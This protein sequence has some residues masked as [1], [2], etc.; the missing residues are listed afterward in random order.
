MA[1]LFILSSQI[2]LEN[3]QEP[4]F[5]AS[6]NQTL[7]VN[8]TDPISTEIPLFIGNQSNENQTNYNS[9]A[10]PALIPTLE[11]LV[12]NESQSATP[13]PN[14]AIPSPAEPEIIPDPSPA[15]PSPEVQAP[16]ADPLCGQTISTSV[17]LTGDLKN[18]SG[19]TICPG[20]G[21]T[22]ISHNLVLDCNGY[23]I[24]G[25]RSSGSDGVTSNSA[26][27]NTIKNCIINNFTIGV[28]FLNNIR[29]TIVNST[30]AN[31]SNFG[32]YIF[33]SSGSQGH[34]I[35]IIDTVI[36]STGGTGIGITRHYN[37]TL[38]RLQ[39][40]GTNVGIS[41]SLSNR[42]LI[43]K[44]GIYKI[45]TNS[46]SISNSSFNSILNLDMATGSQGILL[47]LNS[48]NNTIFNNSIKNFSTAAIKLD[49]GPLTLNEITKNRIKDSQYGI[50]I[51]SATGNRIYDN[52]F[53]MNTIDAY[54]N[55]TNQWNI[56]KK[57]GL[58]VIGGQFIS[59]NYWDGYTGA[60]TNGDFIGDTSLPYKSENTIL[61]GGDYGPLVFPTPFTCNGNISTSLPLD[62]DI[63]N[64]N[65]TGLNIIADN[66]ILDCNG[67]KISGNGTGMGITIQGRVNVTIANCM[68]SKFDTGI[69]ASLA[70]GNIKNNT[71]SNCSYGI[72]GGNFHYSKIQANYLQ[73]NTLVGISLSNAQNS[74]IVGNIVNSMNKTTSSYGIKLGLLNTY[75]YN[76]T[77]ENNTAINSNIG[78]G[79]T[80]TPGIIPSGGNARNTIRSN[81][82]SNNYKGIIFSS[83]Y[84]NNLNNSVYDNYFNN[85]IN[86][87]DAN[88]FNSWNTTLQAGPNIMGG[89]NISGNF[90]S[91][92][93]G[94]DFDFDGLGDTDIPYTSG[95]NIT[96]GG[97][98][99]PLAYM[100]PF[101]VIYDVDAYVGDASPD[102]KCRILG[103]AF[104]GPSSFDVQLENFTGRCPGNIISI[105]NYSIRLGIAGAT[106]FGNRGSEIFITDKNAPI[107]A[108][109]SFE[110]SLILHAGRK[111][112]EPINHPFTY[113]ITAT[114]TWSPPQSFGYTIYA[115]GIEKYYDTEEFSLKK[116]FKQEG[117]LSKKC[118]WDW[119]L[120]D[121]ATSPYT[122]I[123]DYTKVYARG[124]SDH[125][126]W[127]PSKINPF[128]QRIRLCSRGVWRD[129]KLSIK[130]MLLEEGILDL[131]WINTQVGVYPGSIAY[132][133]ELQF[134]AKYVN[135][136]GTTD[137]VPEPG[138]VQRQSFDKESTN[139]NVKLQMEDGTESLYAITY[140]TEPWIN[141]TNGTAFL[142]S[143]EGVK[144]FTR[145]KTDAP[146]N[147]TR[148]F[149]QL[150]ADCGN[151]SQ[152]A[153]YSDRN[154]DGIVEAGQYIV[155]MDGFEL[156]G[157]PVS[158]TMYGAFNYTPPTAII[159]RIRPASGTTG[160]AQEGEDVNFTGHGIPLN[161]TIDHWWK[162][163][164]S[165][166][167]GSIASFNTKLLPPANPHVI[168]YYVKDKTGLWSPE[169]DFS[170]QTLIVNKP[171]VA[172]VNFIKGIVDDSGTLKAVAGESIDFS[173]YGFDTDGYVTEETWII[174][175]QV[176]P[177]STQYAYPE[178]TYGDQKVIFYARDNTGTYSKNVTKT[179]HVIKRP[180]ILAH[181]YLRSPSEMDDLKKALQADNYQVYTVDLRKPVSADVNF[182]IPL[183]SDELRTLAIVYA[184][185]EKTRTFYKDIKELMALNG[186]T[187]ESIF[188]AKNK[189]KASL[190]D[191]KSALLS[192]RYLVSNES[193]VYPPMTS[194]IDTLSDIESHLNDA[195]SAIYLYNLISDDKFF[196]NLWKNVIRNYEIK[197]DYTLKKEIGILNLSLPVPLPEKV[198]PAV[199]GLVET[200]VIKIP[201]SITLFS[202]EFSATKGNYT[203][204]LS[205]KL[206]VKYIE[207]KN[208]EGKIKLKG[209]LVISDI[210]FGFRGKIPFVGANKN[211]V[212]QQQEDAGTGLAPDEIS[213]LD[214]GFD[215][216]V[217]QGNANGVLRLNTNSMLATPNN[218]G[219]GGTFG[220]DV[221][222]W[223][224]GENG[225]RYI[226][227]TKVANNA[228]P[229]IS[230]AYIGATEGATVLDNDF[231]IN[232][233]NATNAGLRTGAYHF[234][235]PNL[236][237]GTIVQDAEEEAQYF[238]D[239]ARAFINNNHLP[240]MLDIE[241]R[242][243]S[244][245]STQQLS[246]WISTWSSYIEDRT[247]I[248]PIL[249]MGRC[250][251]CS[252]SNSWTQMVEPRITTHIL[253]V[254]R[255]QVRTI[256]DDYENIGA[257]AV[258][259]SRWRIW[260]FSET[261]RISG[262][263]GDV[264]LNYYR[265]F[266]E[267]L[268]EQSY[269]QQIVQTSGTK[270]ADQTEENLNIDLTDSDQKY[271]YVSFSLK[272]SSSI[273]DLKLANADIRESAKAIGQKIDK[274]KEKTGVSA[275]NLVGSGMG[276]MAANYYT[277]YG[278]RQDVKKVI[279]IGSP[280][281]GSDLIKFGPKFIKGAIDALSNYIPVGG[282]ILAEIIKFA[283]DLILGEAAVQMEPES[284]FV[285][286]MNLN[287][288]N[289]S[290]E[291]L[292][293]EWPGG[294]DFTNKNVQYLNLF[295]VGPKIGIPL[296]LTLT[297]LRLT[298][299]VI[300]HTFE[301]L[302]IWWGDLFTNTISAKQ[303]KMQ[304]KEI[305]GWS[306]FHWWIAG[307]G[308]TINAVKNFLNG[309]PVAY[310]AST[311]STSQAATTLDNS[312]MNST[313]YEVLGPYYGFL[314]NTN[315]SIMDHLP[316][317][318]RSNFFLDIAAKDKVFKLTYKPTD[319]VWVPE[320]DDYA[321]CNNSLNL[322]IIRPDGSR[323]TP[324]MANNGSIIYIDSGNEIYYLINE[325]A[326]GNW[327]MEVGGQ[328]IT[329]EYAEYTTE[330]TY[331]S[332]L[333]MLVTTGNVST[334]EP[335]SGVKIMAMLLYNGSIV[336]GANMTAEITLYGNFTL[337]ST[338]PNMTVK[339]FD[340][341][342]HGDRNSNDGY[343]AFNFTNTSAE[344]AYIVK[345]IAVVNSSKFGVGGAIV[346]RSAATAFIIEKPIDLTLNSTGI[347]FSNP[348]PLH[349]NTVRLD[350]II[351]NKRNGKAENAEIE[352]RDNLTTL[353]FAII[354]VTG[355]NQTVASVLW[356]AT[357]GTHNIT[358]IVSPFNSFDETNYS[359]NL[360]WKVLNVGD[361]VLPVADAGPD[362]VA[363][364][365][366]PVFFDASP[367]YDNNKIVTYQ[368]DTHLG[369]A[370]SQKIGGV[371]NSIRGYGLL[372][373]H[374]VQLT[375]TDAAGNTDT[376]TLTVY[377]TNDYDV[378]NPVAFAGYD[379][380][381]YIGDPIQFN[382]TAGHDNYGIASHIWDIDTS[383]DSDGD[384]IPDN[385]ADLVTRFPRLEKG[386][387]IPGTY[388]VK[389]T[390][391]DV[392]SNGPREDEMT[393]AV[394]DRISYICLQ[395]K[396]C[397]QIIDEED[398]C[399]NV[400]NTDQKDYDNDGIGDACH[401]NFIAYSQQELEDEMANAWNGETI[402][403]YTPIT[404]SLYIQNSNFTLDCLGALVITND[405]M[406]GIVLQSTA[407]NVTVQNCIVSGASNGIEAFGNN[408]RLYK[409]VI[410]N[411][412]NSGIFITGSGGELRGNEVCSNAIKDIN[413]TGAYSGT[414][415]TC[416]LTSNWNDQSKSG[417]TFRCDPCSIPSNGLILPASMRLCPGSFS[418]P[419]G[420]QAS[421]NNIT[422][423]C[424]D[425][426]LIGGMVPGIAGITV[427]G[428]DYV[429]IVGCDISNYSIGI[430]MKDST[431]SQA[432]YNLIHENSDGIIYANSPRSTIF[433]NTIFANA[434]TQVNLS[435]AQ[436]YQLIG[437]EIDAGDGNGNISAI[438]SSS[439]DAIVQSNIIKGGVKVVGS[440][441]AKVAGNM[442]S[443]PLVNSALHLASGA[444]SAEVT[445]NDISDAIFIGIHAR[446][447][448]N[449]FKNNRIHDVPYGI[450]LDS[451]SGNSLLNDFVTYVTIG[452]FINSTGSNTITNLTGDEV[453]LQTIVA[454]NSSSVTL[455]GIVCD[456]VDS[457][458]E[459][460]FT[461]DSTISK[462]MCSI[463]LQES[464]NN[465]ITQNSIYGASTGIGIDNGFSNNLNNN[466]VSFG[467]YGI[468]ISNSSAGLVTRNWIRNNTVGMYLVNSPSNTIYDNFFSNRVNA[469]TNSTNRW[470][471]N[472]TKGPLPNVIGGLY[473]GGNFW[474]WY[475]GLD[476]GGGTGDH[477]FIND[478]IGDTKIPHTDN[479][480]IASGDFNPL[481]PCIGTCNGST[482]T[483]PTP[484]IPPCN[485]L[486]L[487]LCPG[488]RPVVK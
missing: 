23:T 89:A 153:V 103:G 322:T 186:T 362:Q 272:V 55:N 54:D 127:A 180:V 390:V 305:D 78:I 446:S 71:I 150:V 215:E 83:P 197:F 366:T 233:I 299:P 324:S 487:E 7:L 21:L 119:Y 6:D 421:A 374:T 452:A 38:S 132:P 205:A 206:K 73:N 341:G 281:H 399:P 240:P 358:V 453:D 413:M 417:C 146:N 237:T 93:P 344:D 173:G 183:K 101:D 265:I 458:I 19:G 463:S 439:N 88:G 288:K 40:N 370:T 116:T 396:D 276:G 115:K 2:D 475:S 410:S 140:Y 428:P 323:I 327:G 259:N 211:S 351:M 239:N 357:Y 49:N 14:E 380:Q 223:K 270:S 69:S 303:D 296:P 60:D 442:I 391:D 414:T 32:A 450:Y 426:E 448:S 162:S 45:N 191:L 108:W 257:W 401:C 217:L 131:N 363:R 293:Y 222:H 385:D 275:V 384:F 340:D 242:G 46:I 435:S 62:R 224:R 143:S 402:C 202:K 408:N 106:Y 151:C 331:M 195:D 208:E 221:D 229:R 160:L 194:F 350:A 343:Y 66:L 51:K 1:I 219:L 318:N 165:G 190:F 63:L 403:T 167:I 427:N 249:Y 377:V 383:R 87:F 76:N 168:Y 311:Q 174:D 218:G 339:L 325:T 122:K 262:I 355:A 354:N 48:Q 25:N 317:V 285:K 411:N 130:H 264:D 123:I 102:G 179:I 30:I 455:N 328:N 4:L 27:N 332:L 444:E 70:N 75:T 430:S 213:L 479:E 231:L 404:T 61:I 267:Q 31:F 134:V 256:P 395:D 246:E 406:P 261:G 277:N 368:W 371:Y 326:Q 302:F 92:Y 175:G 373:P 29:S 52:Y 425:T 286:D 170:V 187:T 462:S 84:V 420:L 440:L 26:T 112:A 320:E 43:E 294:E 144:N 97:D 369:N 177:K 315:N 255:Y 388:H 337:N 313:G 152:P 199:M 468:A 482:I 484:T 3:P 9:D 141:Q 459:L 176:R 334:Y 118:Y 50:Y 210:T 443:A 17:K 204:S 465:F 68:I 11:I 271:P 136:Y 216:T 460:E 436:Y 397:D 147:D 125:S 164:K 235:Y 248:Q 110:P 260:Q 409:N 434:R 196:E 359:N 481:L 253:W 480:S 346:N 418:L 13:T 158:Y 24:R 79:I 367:S 113:T 200:G 372:G 171:P 393:V 284:E 128:K 135:G 398:N 392:G 100:P 139:P 94:F 449:T 225:Q 466:T 212:Q 258:A 287:G 207:P 220:I 280:L 67:H 105:S 321:I 109:F 485:K 438:L 342:L 56:T 356:N 349:G 82:I 445:S 441:R 126:I 365:G 298:D 333:K 157:G 15:D 486:K 375:V 104:L 209:S 415:N 360:A 429:H 53:E 8:F 90:W 295:G 96:N 228:L 114:G 244:G 117:G 330:V 64:C 36:Y 266:D 184:T 381:A 464:S 457:G 111:T 312:T 379:Q 243:T 386:Y 98:F 172:Y 185:L 306:S 424:K 301:Q 192:A 236:R 382:A 203:G 291:W 107:Y 488:Y 389:L 476:N 394:F 226:N 329:C 142:N 234:A 269:Y 33:G 387:F 447:G 279:T 407:T 304:S 86:V 201:G 155:W 161:N 254:A 478:G 364:K 99:R 47:T 477:A 121:Q 347:S 181:D 44:N 412:N 80:F 120:T 159:D 74:T 273:I 300:G 437:N 310:A 42:S 378:E 282:K 338:V 41:L 376:D 431:G 91:D 163:H 28:Q 198:K 37:T 454:F 18:S 5:N 433:E 461:N 156:P 59:G 483:T 137:P 289:P 138:T 22:F 85:T 314:N 297:T 20:G 308:D 169:S 250:G 251:T 472:R 241:D 232:I 81:F 34:N 58:N 16:M 12:T 467:D 95:T 309:N 319:A 316:M 353:G 166:R 133:Q 469:Y 149:P 361:N 129:G 178:D 188:E 39:I 182:I 148:F 263:G 57:S 247:G 10:Q 423:L 245:L 278:Y 400:A 419:S 145:F 471:I 283:I 292:L 432:S 252:G 422:I 348:S 193:S 230:F 345:A 307:N 227:W 474:S 189:V 274:V 214:E 154:D 470:N 65:G 268:T 405:T 238:L 290:P 124:N 352:F 336:K 416:N 72:S 77:I 35:S 473:L 451:S 335:N 456:P